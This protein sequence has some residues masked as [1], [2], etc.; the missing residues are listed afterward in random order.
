MPSIFAS[1]YNR[2]LV[3]KRGCACDAIAC[4]RVVRSG[5]SRLAGDAYGRLYMVIWLGEI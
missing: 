3:V 4:D 2:R 1:T 5:E